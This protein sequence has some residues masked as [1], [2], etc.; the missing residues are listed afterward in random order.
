MEEKNQK[1]FE[2]EIRLRRIEMA[3]GLIQHENPSRDF[4]KTCDEAS[5][6]YEWISECHKQKSHSKK[7]LFLLL[8]NNQ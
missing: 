6:I 1:Q 5:N 2:I 3:L 4:D 8:K 7:T